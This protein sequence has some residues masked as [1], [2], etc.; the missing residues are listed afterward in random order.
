MQVTPETSLDLWTKNGDQPP[1]PWLATR[2]RELMAAYSRDG[3][4]VAYVSDESG[5]YEIYVRPAS[6]E[7]ANWQISNEGGEEP[8]WSRD[9]RELF[10]RNG[11]KWMAAEVTTEPQFK[12][13]PP[14][15]LLKG[16]T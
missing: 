4:Y 2:F 9:G 1:R 5:Q 8:L 7:G 15:M 13:S 16:H 6:G 12:A 14:R 11:P 10:F 3:K